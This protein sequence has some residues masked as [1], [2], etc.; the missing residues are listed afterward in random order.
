MA[1]A[2]SEEAP[3]LESPRRLVEEIGCLYP[4]EVAQVGCILNAMTKSLPAT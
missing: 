2:S 1:G 3:L 4:I